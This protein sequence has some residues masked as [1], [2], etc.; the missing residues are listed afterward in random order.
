MS[1]YF[2]GNGNGNA[3]GNSTVRNVRFADEQ[4]GSA[5]SSTSSSATST[6]GGSGK[7]IEMIHRLFLVI[8]MY[9]QASSSQF[10]SRVFLQCQ[11]WIVNYYGKKFVKK[12]Q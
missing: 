2:T 12:S 11:L 10:V 8:A 7:E 5:T 9:C 6:S 1:Y 4:N 3:S